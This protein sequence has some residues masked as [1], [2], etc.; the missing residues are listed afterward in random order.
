[1]ALASMILVGND[2]GE[3]GTGSKAGQVAHCHQVTVFF[4]FVGMGEI[5]TQVEFKGWD[6]RGPACRLNLCKPWNVGGTK[7]LWYKTLLGKQT[8]A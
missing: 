5:L 7:N 4:N 2:L 3:P 1:M 8:K 6:N